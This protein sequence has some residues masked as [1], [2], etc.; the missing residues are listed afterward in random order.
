MTSL[1]IRNSYPG[2]LRACGGSKSTGLRWSVQSPYNIATV[3]PSI[4]EG[5]CS[6]SLEKDSL[7]TMGFPTMLAIS[8]LALSVRRAA[9]GCSSVGKSSCHWEDSVRTTSRF[10]RKQTFA[11]EQSWLDM[12]SWRRQ[13]R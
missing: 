9:R 7:A 1:Y 11:G 10:A 13:A 3:R 8:I 5:D 6:H 12:L 2:L 4:L